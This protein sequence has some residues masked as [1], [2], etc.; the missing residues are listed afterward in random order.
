[1]V[2]LNRRALSG[3]RGDGRRGARRA[4][5]GLPQGSRGDQRRRASPRPRV[6]PFFAGST[7]VTPVPRRV[8]S[9][10]QL[11]RAREEFESHKRRDERDL[12]AFE[13][14]HAEELGAAESAID[15]RW[16][17]IAREGDEGYREILAS[18]DAVRGDFQRRTRENA[19][20]LV[21]A[22]ADAS[23]VG[24]AL[25]EFQAHVE[26]ETAYQR[27]ASDWAVAASRD[28]LADVDDDTRRAAVETLERVNAA[29]VAGRAARSER[30][31]ETFGD[32]SAWLDRARETYGERAFDMH[33]RIDTLDKRLG[34]NRRAGDGGRGRLRGGA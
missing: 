18:F 16:K 14:Q 34:I 31:A 11:A 3:A 25:R 21:G 17:E 2:F 1:M 5:R 29:H 27:V 19:S 13:A 12:A 7:D 9:R 22:R 26:T 4:A 32:L 6:T 30:Y 15:T 10:A 33:E 24:D 8:P 23:R 20:A 28:F